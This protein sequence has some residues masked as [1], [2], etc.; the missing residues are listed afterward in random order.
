MVGEFKDDQLQK[1]NHTKDYG[2]APNGNNRGFSRIQVESYNE[3]LNST[4]SDCRYGNTTHGKRKGV[5][6]IIKVL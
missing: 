5:K 6:F 1:H 3:K 4:P 2:T